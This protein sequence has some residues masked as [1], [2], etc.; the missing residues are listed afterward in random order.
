MKYDGMTAS[1]RKKNTTKGGNTMTNI[2]DERKNVAQKY[3]KLDTCDHIIFKSIVEMTFMLL[4]TMQEVALHE[5][6]NNQKSND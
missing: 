6:K 1:V 4:K 2:K 5:S 3:K